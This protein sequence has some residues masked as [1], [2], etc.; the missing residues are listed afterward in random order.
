M[1]S[2]TISKGSERNIVSIAW[3]EKRKEKG[4]KESEGAEHVW[5]T[6]M[7]RKSNVLLY[8]L[9]PDGIQE[10]VLQL[11]EGLLERNRKKFYIISYEY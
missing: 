2:R 1:M 4:S 5:N 9:R 10:A 11:L 8:K 7:Y 6:G 3:Q